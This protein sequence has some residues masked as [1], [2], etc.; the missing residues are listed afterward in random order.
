MQGISPKPEV[1]S[2]PSQ[3]SKKELHMRHGRKIKF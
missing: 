3:I 1:Y 2:E